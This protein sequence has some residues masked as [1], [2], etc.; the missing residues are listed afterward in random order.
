MKATLTFNLPEEQHDHAYA[1]AGTD[2]LLVISD[3]LNEIRTK[4]KYD[5]GEFKDCDEKTLEIVRDFIVE[6]KQDR[7]LPELY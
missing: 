7:N 1:L 6:L 2:A 4:L 5:S 3:I